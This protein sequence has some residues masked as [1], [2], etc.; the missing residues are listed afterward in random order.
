MIV[1]TVAQLVEQLIRNQQVGGSS[2][3]SS[4]IF[5]PD[6][7]A[8]FLHFFKEILSYMN[9]IKKLLAYF[10]CS[11]TLL[12][13]TYYSN[14]ESSLL[15]GDL[16]NLLP[17]HEQLDALYFYTSYLK[18]TTK[19]FSKF[20]MSSFQ[21]EIIENMEQWRK[22]LFAYISN[23]IPTQKA[24]FF[25]CIY[26]HINPQSNIM[27]SAPPTAITDFQIDI[28]QNVSSYNTAPEVISAHLTYGKLKTAQIVL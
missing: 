2:P 11:F 9:T 14:A 21:K 20:D 22:S 17:I 24:L 10:L 5:W 6:F 13:N 25:C 27:L 28:I 19:T 4:S 23:L 26:H 12:S 1:A 18:I 15:H 16:L 3:P 8:I 7:Q